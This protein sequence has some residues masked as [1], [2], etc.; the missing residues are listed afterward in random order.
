MNYLAHLLLAGPDDASRIG[1]LLGDFVKG[2]PASLAGRYPAAV[3]AGIVMHRK[4]DRFTDE[5]AA[6]RTARDLLAPPRRRFA[7]IVVDIFFDHFLTVHWEQ[8]SPLPLPA[9]LAEIYAA[10]AR[11]PA[12]LGDELTRALPRMREEN[13]LQSYGTLAGLALTFRRVAERSPRTAPI[14]ASCHDLTAHYASF[15]RAFHQF[16]PDAQAR[17]DALRSGAA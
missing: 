13:W 4:L 17:A 3:I 7:G 9:F 16:F 15:D 12:W 6:F 10:F 1:N 5:H 8:F 11:H 2:T 14:R